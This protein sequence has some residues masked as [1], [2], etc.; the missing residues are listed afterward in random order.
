MFGTTWSCFPRAR[1]DWARRGHLIPE[2]SLHRLA[3]TLWWKAGW[4]FCPTSTVVT[5]FGPMRASLLGSLNTRPRKSEQFGNRG[6][7][8]TQRRQA[9]EPRNEQDQ[10]RSLGFNCMPDTLHMLFCLK[11]LK[12]LWG[13]YCD[14][15][16]STEEETEAKCPEVLGFKSRPVRC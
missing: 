6:R 8:W 3:R 5:K 1:A 4:E 15:S 14:Y 13:R 11:L 10:G 9:A 2:Q 7:S 16:C 12:S